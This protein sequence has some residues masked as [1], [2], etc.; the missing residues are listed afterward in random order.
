MHL[1]LQGLNHQPMESFQLP[2]TPTP[3]FLSEDVM[4]EESLTTPPLH[5]HCLKLGVYP[6]GH[7]QQGLP[8]GG[9]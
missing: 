6:W 8:G 2:L 9:G 1:S 4:E 5:S 3:A 7:L